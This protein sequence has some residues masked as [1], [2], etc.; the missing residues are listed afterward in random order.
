[1]ATF[2][3]APIKFSSMELITIENGLNLL[4]KDYREDIFLRQTED[5]TRLKQ[6]L[7][8]IRRKINESYVIEST[9]ISDKTDPE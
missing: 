7:E 2:S 4:E 1:M 3:K 5:Y 6:I 8:E 9:Y